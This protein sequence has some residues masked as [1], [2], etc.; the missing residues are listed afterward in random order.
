MGH[1][2]NINNITN[3]ASSLARRP[4]VAQQAPHGSS[5]QSQEDSL[6]AAVHLHLASITRLWARILYRQV[7]VHGSLTYLSLFLDHVSSGLTIDLVEEVIA[8][9]LV[10]AG[11][12][13]VFL[14]DFKLNLNNFL[15]INNINNPSFLLSSKEKLSTKEEQVQKEKQQSPS[16]SNHH[17]KDKSATTG[18]IATIIY[19]RKSA[20]TS[21]NS[22]NSSSNR[23]EAK[24]N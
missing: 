18:I 13:D 16:S 22:I 3:N 20:T 4:V 6:F 8:L 7:V 12:T 19:D 1:P 9:A 21:N 17:P 11:V 10:N 5:Q 15:S 24:K 14:L 2:H 23:C